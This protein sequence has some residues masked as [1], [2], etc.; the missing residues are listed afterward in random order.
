MMVN[1]VSLVDIAFDEQRRARRSGNLKMKVI[2]R[3]YR[4]LADSP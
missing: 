1:T 4:P 3:F 2:S